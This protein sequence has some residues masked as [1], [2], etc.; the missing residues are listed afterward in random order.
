M[1]DRIIKVFMATLLFLCLL[2]MPYGYF[3][4]VRFCALFVFIY[5]AMQAKKVGNQSSM[6]F[7]IALA[8]LFQPFFKISLGRIM[9]NIVDVFVAIVLIYSLFS[10]HSKKSSNDLG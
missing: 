3:Q 9:W 4:F 7:Y 6:L 5:F 2:D 8:V 10:N 1:K